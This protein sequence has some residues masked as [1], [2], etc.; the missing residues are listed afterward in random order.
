MEFKIKITD[1]N[2]IKPT[3]YR[4]LKH[5]SE[6]R[7]LPNKVRSS[8]VGGNE[9]REA[10]RSNYTYFSTLTFTSDDQR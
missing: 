6:L 5:T 8:A 3:K 2:K 1:F 10:S 9:Y 4:D 7:H